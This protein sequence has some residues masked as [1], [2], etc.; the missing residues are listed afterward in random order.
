MKKT[1]ILRQL[2]KIKN[3]HV[4]DDSFSRIFKQDKKKN[5]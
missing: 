5:K 4:L 1:N 2:R 3:T